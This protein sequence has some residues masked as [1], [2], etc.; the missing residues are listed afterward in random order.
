MQFKP[1]PQ[2]PDIAVEEIANSPENTAMKAKELF[3]RVMIVAE[4]LA[5]SGQETP[6]KS[7]RKTPAKTQN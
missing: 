3:K 4:L 5:K 7:T 2:T 1:M 6:V